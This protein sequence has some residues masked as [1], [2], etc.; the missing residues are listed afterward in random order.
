MTTSSLLLIPAAIDCE[1]MDEEY[2][3]SQKP[4]IHITH[5]NIRKLSDI[6]N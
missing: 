6:K 2:S 4:P 1:S 3:P 5:H